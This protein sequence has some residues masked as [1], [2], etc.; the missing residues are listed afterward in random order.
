M[1]KFYHMTSRLEV[2][3]PCNKIGKPLKFTDFIMLHNDVHKMLRKRWQYLDFVTPKKR[4][5]LILTS[6]D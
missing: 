1:K 4:L 2:I 6:Y 3:T 5:Q